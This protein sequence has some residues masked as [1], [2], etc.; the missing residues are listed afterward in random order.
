[1][2]A[3]EVSILVSP[4]HIFSSFKEAYNALEQHSLKNGYGF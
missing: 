3:I 2:D 1:M 4:N